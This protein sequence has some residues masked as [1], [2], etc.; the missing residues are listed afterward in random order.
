MELTNEFNLKE[1]ERS[2]KDYLSKLDLQKMIDDSSDKRDKIMFIEGPPTLNGE[3][4]A[5]H[6]RGRVFKDLWYRFNTLNLKN[7]IFNAGWDTQGLPVE[8]QA[9]KELGITDGKSGITTQQQIE[10]LVAQ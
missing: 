4:H 8:L 1:I 5:G 7:V 3:P 10:N 6:L 2:A 9:E